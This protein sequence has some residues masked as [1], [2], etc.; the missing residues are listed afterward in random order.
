MLPDMC[1][2]AISPLFLFVWCPFRLDNAGRIITGENG[3]RV[4]K[5]KDEFS[6]D[7]RYWLRFVASKASPSESF[8][9]KVFLAI[10]R[11][12]LLCNHNISM[13]LRSD[14]EKIHREFKDHVELDVEKGVFEVNATRPKSM[15]LLT[16]YIFSVARTILDAAPLESKIC[17]KVRRFLE[18][19]S[20]L[21][22]VP[23]IIHKQELQRILSTEES[24]LLPRDTFDA[25]AKCLVNSGDIIFYVSVELVVRDVQW[26]G[27]KIMGDLL[28]FNV[29]CDASDGSKGVFTA[30]DLAK[31]LEEHVNQRKT[32]LRSM[33]IR[34]E[35]SP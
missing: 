31:L 19:S 2:R 25:V 12:D 1:N 30:V 3:R 10:T 14:L 35:L 7:L 5:T 34:R 20:S 11:K 21:H 26:F 4:L 8:K 13:W 29:Q 33:F 17:E 32:S 24:L 28:H 18:T 23:P 6:G 15:A 27:N 9:P 22:Q 16:S